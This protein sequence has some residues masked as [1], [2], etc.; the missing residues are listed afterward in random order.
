MGQGQIHLGAGDDEDAAPDQ[1]V[2]QARGPF[3]VRLAEI[4]VC[5][6]LPAP[7][8]IIVGCPPAPYETVRQDPAGILWLTRDPL[9]GARASY[10][11]HILP[12]T[13][14]DLSRR[15]PRPSGVAIPGLVAAWRAESC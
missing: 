5:R 3:P 4:P 2:A 15:V 11:G 6:D 9:S 8:G 14:G 12:A 7:L 13:S 10:E 1:L